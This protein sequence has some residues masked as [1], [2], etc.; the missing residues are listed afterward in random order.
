[1]IR[2][3][4]SRRFAIVASLLVLLTSPNVSAEGESLNDVQIE[5]IRQNC[6]TAQSGM[7]RLELS[8]AV[9]RRNRGVSY[10]ST[11]KLMA[12]LNSRIAFNKL[13]A[14]TLASLTAEINKKRGEFIDNYITYN[15]SLNVTMKLSNC[16]E[17]PV[18]FY[19]YLTQTR[20]LRTKLSTGLD[21]IDRLMDSYQTALNELKQP[22][23][24][25]AE[26]EGVAQ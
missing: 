13:S 25:P 17:Q 5:L 21:D 7:Q 2:M 8:E 12:A 22:T 11:L 4:Y 14:P 18:T 19:D 1:M 9:T 6:V 15:N 3:K 10:E 16:K 26:Q 20:Q 24:Q 23:V